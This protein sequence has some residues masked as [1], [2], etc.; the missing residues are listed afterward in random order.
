MLIVSVLNCSILCWSSFIGWHQP[1]G[2]HRSDRR[3]AISYPS[4]YQKNDHRQWGF[5]SH[6]GYPFIARWMVCGG[7]ILLEWMMNRGS[8]ISGNIHLTVFDQPFETV[9][10]ANISLEGC[11]QEYQVGLFQNAV[12]KKHICLT[13]FDNWYMDLFA[14]N[15]RK[16]CAFILKTPSFLQH[17]HDTPNQGYQDICPRF[18]G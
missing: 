14:G 9:C 6:G 17:A 4:N 1:W 12:A 15:V 16:P 2:S 5:H 7:K 10:E 8:P 3:I 18:A 11:P 13:P